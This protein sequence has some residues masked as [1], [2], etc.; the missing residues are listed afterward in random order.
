MFFDIRCL[1]TK[2]RVEFQRV[3]VVATNKRFWQNNT[4]FS[5]GNDY[6]DVVM[7]IVVVNVV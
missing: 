7:L 3:P 2:T 5:I 6:E 4:S 1:C